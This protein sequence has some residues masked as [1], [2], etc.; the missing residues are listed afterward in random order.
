[1]WPSQVENVFR[2]IGK[3]HSFKNKSSAGATNANPL[4]N[5]GTSSVHF[6]NVGSFVF[7]ALTSVKEDKNYKPR[8]RSG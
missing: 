2:M 3:T 1:M 4:S 7:N 5:P 8:G 6:A